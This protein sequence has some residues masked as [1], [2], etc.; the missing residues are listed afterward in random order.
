[1]VRVAQN[2]PKV[3]K[4]GSPLPYSSLDII[5]GIYVKEIRILLK[6]CL[7]TPNI[8]QPFKK[9]GFPKLPE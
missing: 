7:F 3:K 6:P 9:G 2:T 8:G 4:V 1:L 5:D